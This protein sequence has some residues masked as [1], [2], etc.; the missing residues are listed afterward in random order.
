[1]NK[2]FKLIILL[3][4]CF[5]SAYNIYASYNVPNTVRIGLEYKYKNVS[6]V[7]IT[8]DSILIGS[9]GVVDTQIDGSGKGFSVNITNENFVKL[10]YVSNNYNDVFE[11][12]LNYENAFPAYIGKDLWGVYLG[13]YKNY[14]DALLKANELGAT[15]SKADNDKM[16][17]KDGEWTILI[18][19]NINPQI[20]ATNKSNITLNDRSYRGV[21]EFGR[22]RGKNITAVNVVNIDDYL[23]SVVPSE[24]PASYHQEALKAQAIAARTYTT[25]NLHV[26]NL[27]GYELCDN[28][29]CQMYK[30]FDNENDKT[31]KAVDDTKGLIAYYNNI[32][33]NAVF[34]ASSGGH[35]ANSEDV[36]IEQTPYL[37]GV[38]EI[39][40]L[41]RNNWTRTYTTSDIEA[42]VTAKG[43]KIGK[44]KDIVISKISQTGH[45]T[46]LKI[47]GTTGTKTLKN[48][49]IRS[50][51]SPNGGS[52]ESRI[53]TINDKGSYPI[54]NATTEYIPS[55][56]N[57][58]NN[59][60]KE[61][62]NENN[63]KNEY[64][65]LGSKG[66]KKIYYVNNTYISGANGNTVSKKNNIIVQDI[67]G[68]TNSYYSNQNQS[69]NVKNLENNNN[70]TFDASKPNIGSNMNISN[71]PVS[72]ANSSGNFVFKG[73]GWGHG[74]GMSQK[75]AN[76]MAQMGYTYKQILEYYYTG[77]EVK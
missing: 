76:G 23:Y 27:D 29:H 14:N 18:F 72:T 48:E 64:Y 17:L 47:V 66:N 55:D 68:N 6:K 58:V 16:I 54:G 25:T 20:K 35:T 67:K 10:S 22:Y 41:D 70:I 56:N 60:F 31:N 3:G 49:N 28:I 45:I 73:Y 13:G 38:P 4:F 61:E 5:S 2:F 30:G 44:V 1:M 42:I 12:C 39:N 34:H 15:V 63:D 37:K 75:G 43:D 59:D 50:Y 26:H 65:V 74:A 9:N 51:F 24:M 8:E 11:Y 36:W 7:P 40:E 46:E 33:I 71:T 53:F 62:I 52:L 19:D 57:G 69:Q 77:I 32:P 21:I